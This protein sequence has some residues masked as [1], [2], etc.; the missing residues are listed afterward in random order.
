VALVSL[1]GGVSTPDG[2]SLLLALERHPS[3]ID[4]ELA[5]RPV[6]Y[7]ATA[8]GLVAKWRGT[9]LAWPL[10]DAVVDREGR[11]CALH[12]GDSFVRPDPTTPLTRT[13][14]YRWNGFGF[15]ALADADGACARLFG[16]TSSSAGAP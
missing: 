2:P 6:V 4:G 11:L 3:A 12:R 1:Q 15:S 8:H 10:L 7:A 13:M 14:R 16:V 9:A 5:L